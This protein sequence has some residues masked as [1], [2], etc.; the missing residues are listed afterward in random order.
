MSQL[1]TPLKIRGIELKNRIA[2]SPMC[3]YSSHDGFAGDWHLV[4]LGSRAVGGA[5]LVLTE[6]AAV[7]KE[8]RISPYDLGI[9]KEK[10]I[11][12]LK[13]IT[14]FIH[15]QGAVAGIQLAHAGRKASKTEPWNGDKLITED[16][17]GWQTIGPSA[18]PFSPDSDMPL[19]MEQKDIDRVVQDFRAAAQRAIKAGFKVIEIHAAHGYLIHEFLSPLS[20]KRTDDY[21]GSFD[22]R[23][24]FLLEVA[25]A[26][27]SVWPDELPLFVRVSATD[28]VEGGWSIDDSVALA[29]MLKDKGVDLVD[30]S[31]GAILPDIK[32]PA[33]PN[34]QVPF[35]EA[36]KKTGILTGAVGIIVSAQQAEDII[37]EGKAD[38]VLL[39][40][41]M[42]RD[43]HFPLHAAMELGHDIKW[44]VQYERGKRNK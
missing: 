26:V 7:S 31:S 5:G 35:A 15:D 29:Q 40:R 13:I 18:I 43:P 16:E 20:N 14:D 28:W 34:Y 8:G 44:P 24:R 38:I 42:L 21:G 27:R 12:K 11:Q 2:V 3:Q 9:W 17:G 39:A 41:E 36:V 33:K 23:I 30:C 25:A 6:A 19:E 1:F 4:H 32:I 37:A 10:H 22:N